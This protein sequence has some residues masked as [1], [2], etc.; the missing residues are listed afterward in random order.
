MNECP[1]VDLHLIE[2]TDNR[3]YKKC[4]PDTDSIHP[5]VILAVI[6][7]QTNKNEILISDL[8]DKPCNIGKIFNLDRATCFYYLEQLQKMGKL[9]VIRTAGLDVVKLKH[10]TNFYDTIQEY[11]RAINGVAE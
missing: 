5:L 8:L 11:Y 2:L 4:I 10:Q 7:D 6:E 9:E 1:L 3:D